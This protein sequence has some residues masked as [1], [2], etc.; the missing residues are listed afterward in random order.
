MSLTKLPRTAEQTVVLS[1]DVWNELATRVERLEKFRVTAPL[2]MHDDAGGIV[3]GCNV[4]KSCVIVTPTAA[5]SG[6]GKYTGYIVNPPATGAAATGNLTS[7]EIGTNGTTAVRIVNTRE[8]GKATHDL[9]FDGS[10]L[11]TKFIGVFR[12]TGAD[13]VAVYAIDG[14]QW[15][16]C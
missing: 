15:K 9:I 1:G 2:E 5:A 13:G 11:P 16:D 6:G 14:M 7:A 12:G 3:V 8:E 10:R 4:L